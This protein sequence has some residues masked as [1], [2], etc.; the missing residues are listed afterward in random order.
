MHQ[1]HEMLENAND[2]GQVLDVTQRYLTSFGPADF[3]TIPED[4]RAARIRAESDVDYWNLRLADECRDLWGT[5]RDGRMITE[6]SQFFLRASVR[7]SHL[8]GAPAAP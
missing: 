5:D 3:V 7:L 4:C 2:V 8:R 6:L 1:W